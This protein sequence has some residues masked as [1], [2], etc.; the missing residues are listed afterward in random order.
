[1]ADELIVDGV[2]YKTRLPESYKNR[3]KYAGTD[4]SRV[5]A[6]MP[7]TILRLLLKPGSEVDEETPV[8]VLEAM[9]MENELR[10]G[11]KG[12]LAEYFVREGQVVEKGAPLFRL[13]LD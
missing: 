5:C 7:G 6:Q 9:K 3:D 8:L 13:E 12:K 2:A 10:A 1:M 4:H 11:R